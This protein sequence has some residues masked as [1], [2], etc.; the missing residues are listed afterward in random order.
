VH[1]RLSPVDCFLFFSDDLQTLGCGAA[2]HRPSLLFVV[3][4]L[5]EEAA[6]VFFTAPV[7]TL[8][9]P[10]INFASCDSLRIPVLNMGST[11][12]QE[13]YG[14]ISGKKPGR[15]LNPGGVRFQAGEKTNRG[16]TERPAPAHRG[17]S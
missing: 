4:S 13:G 3:N 12:G 9:K 15:I 11:A 7:I 17:G 1:N 10:G 8:E 5:A 2:G 16:K 14:T 6:P